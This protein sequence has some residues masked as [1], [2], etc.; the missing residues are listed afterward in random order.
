MT[1]GEA[2]FIISPPT[3][4]NSTAIADH[5]G[6]AINGGGFACVDCFIEPGPNSVWPGPNG[7][8]PYAYSLDY[9]AYD[10]RS[11]PALI[12]LQ[13]FF[14]DEAHSKGVLCYLYTGPWVGTS[15]PSGVMHLAGW[16]QNKLP[17][18]IG[19]TWDYFSNL[20]GVTNVDDPSISDQYTF[21]VNYLG[22]S[23]VPLS[24]TIVTIDFC[25]PPSSMEYLFGLAQQPAGYN[26]F[27][28][29]LGES[30]QSQDY[31][32]KVAALLGGWQP[33]AIPCPPPP[34]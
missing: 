15:D 9:E 32:N 18:N 2:M 26:I 1:G 19:A 31:N 12:K 8:K 20:I 21:G 14:C 33:S 29:N 28:D 6:F 23:G 24:K 5:G 13:T 17:M 30:N 27:L 7:L 16:T 4:V 11:T 34:S 3:G 22:A 10:G 25:D